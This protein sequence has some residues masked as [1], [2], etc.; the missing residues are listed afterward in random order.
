[1]LREENPHHDRDSHALK[2]RGELLL[3]AG[4]ICAAQ[5]LCDRVGVYTGNLA[6]TPDGYLNIADINKLP[7]GKIGSDALSTRLFQAEGESR[8]THIHRVI[9]EYLGAKWL[10]RCFEDGVSEKRIFALFRQGEGVPTSLRGLH[11]WIAHFSD[12]LAARCIT[13]DPYAILQYGD[14][15]TLALDRVRALL[16]ALKSLSKKN[17]YFRSGDWSRTPASG[18]MRVELRDDILAIMETPG[19]H[20]Q[21]DSLL[22]EAMPGTGSGA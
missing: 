22:L 1:M 14:A 16:A 9:A 21:L 2:D 11:A 13:A 5:V 17:P 6:N 19:R 8:F 10:A 15:E 20:P 12:A 3:A 7:F 18:L 4:A